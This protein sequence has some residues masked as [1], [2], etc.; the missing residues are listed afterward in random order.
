MNVSCPQELT[1]LSSDRAALVKSIKSLAV[2]DETYLPS[3]LVWGWRTL[4]P[5]EP[6]DD[7]ADPSRVTNRYLI[8]MTDGV[9]TLSPNYPTHNGTNR[10]LADKITADLC[11]NAKASG[12]TIYSIAFEVT[13]LAAKSMLQTCASGPDRFFDA[14][15]ADQLSGTFKSIASQLLALRITK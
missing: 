3:G 7:A 1:P 9:N 14:A 10:T 12:I 2:A 6:F 8:L 5:G 4:S 13:D 15:N 11:R